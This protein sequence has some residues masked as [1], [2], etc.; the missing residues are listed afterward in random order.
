MVTDEQLD[1]LIERARP[2]IRRSLR[3]ILN[4]EAVHLF[5]IAEQPLPAGGSWAVVCCILS[6][7]L[8]CL[9][10]SVLKGAD[11][12]GNS[13]QKLHGPPKSPEAPTH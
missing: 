2:E 5:N 4:G 9:T 3:G 6:E 8:A 13:Y 10:E 11:A 12:M 7:P 1:A